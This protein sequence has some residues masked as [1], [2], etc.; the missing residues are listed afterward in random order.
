MKTKKILIVDDETL[1]K[2]SK[3]GFLYSINLLEE[4]AI[5]AHNYEE[6]KQIIHSRKDIVFCLLDC[7]I[8][9]SEQSGDPSL[10]L[11]NPD[12]AYYGI[13]LIPELQN[14]PT[15]IYSAYADE[16]L[17]KKQVREYPNTIIKWAKR[18]FKEKVRE[19][20]CD[21]LDNLL[22]VPTFEEN[23]EVLHFDYSFLSQEDKILV[24]D[25]VHKIKYLQNRAVRDLI[26]IGTYLIEVKE[27]IGHGRF[28]NWV[29]T[30]FSL[31]PGTAKRCMAVARKF[32]SNKLFD[33]V[34]LEK[35]DISASYV[36]A[37]ETTPQKALE[38][39]VD[40]IKKGERISHSKAIELR[41][42]YLNESNKNK[43][44]STQSDVKKKEIEADLLEMVEVNK[45]EKNI[46]ETSTVEPIEIKAETIAESDS[47]VSRSSSAMPERDLGMN[48]DREE[49]HYPLPEKLN[50]I[51]SQKLLKQQIISVQPNIKNHFW[52]FENYRLFCG[53]PNNDLF[54]KKLPQEISIHFS[55]PPC[56]KKHL[57]PEI[58]AET[59]SYFSSSYQEADPNIIK[60]NVKN[61]IFGYVPPLEAAV[62][63]YIFSL[64]VLKVA[65]SMKC[66]CWVAEPNLSICEQILD[67]WR[68]KGDVKRL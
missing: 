54:L 44:N 62:F 59:S 56:D 17:L 58:K 15:C 3:Q 45:S 21:Y 63:S 6:A 50:S 22:A 8:P 18:P 30:E 68:S 57:V 7:Y 26:D 52:Q 67:Y 55:F 33:L 43:S 23:H 34:D 12:F 40:R 2:E 29:K 19:E 61:T 14:V 35:I 4:N 11:K 41:E 16:P 60:I 32:K 49:K 13:R 27:K 10:D 65:M 66:Y 46:T 48:R 9:R 38:E 31:R 20:V 28:E 24:I 25:R 36:L 51:S 47:G 5:F 39:A 53:E 64:D 42:K 37:S 1:S